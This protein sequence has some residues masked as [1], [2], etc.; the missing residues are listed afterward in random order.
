M[1]ENITKK[2]LMA[3]SSLLK[4]PVI[5][6]LGEFQHYTEQEN[7][8]Y[9]PVKGKTGMC[10]DIANSLKSAGLLARIS[11]K[12]VTYKK[13]DEFEALY[14]NNFDRL[15]SDYNKLYSERRKRKLN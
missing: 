5:F 2:R 14:K 15:V 1:D 4:I 8:T 10:S 9:N 6:S 13:T 11:N 3:L 12:P 7:P